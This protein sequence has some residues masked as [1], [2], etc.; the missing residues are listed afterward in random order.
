ML[1][2][3]IFLLQL[4]CGIKIS[5]TQYSTAD[6]GYAPEQHGHHPSY[7]FSYGVKDQHSGDVKSQWETRDNGIIKGHYSVVEPDGSIREVDYTADSKNGFNAVVKTHG[8][9]SHPVVDEHGHHKYV[10]KYS[11]SKINHYSKHQ[12]TIILSSDV[13][14]HESPVAE[15]NE[16]IRHTPSILEVKPNVE[17][18]PHPPS[19]S[20]SHETVYQPQKF[21]PSF[22]INH[23]HSKPYYSEIQHTESFKPSVSHSSSSGGVARNDHPNYYKNQNQNIESDYEDSREFENSQQ[24]HQ[25]QHQF[26]QLQQQRQGSRRQPS[27]SQ[28]LYRKS[29]RLVQRA[30]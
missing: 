27:H 24:Q 2:T 8:P 6:H 29:P 17:L 9:N 30:F 15:I 26:K 4:F 14:Q 28:H 7:S 25:Q 12:D 1:K 22:E 11:Q 13:P 18:H 3:L 23:G 19:H 10:N 21:N 5:M 20:H 16:K